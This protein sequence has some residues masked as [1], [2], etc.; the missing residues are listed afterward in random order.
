MGTISDLEKQGFVVP[1]TIGKP[2]EPE[3]DRAPTRDMEEVSSVLKRKADR[4]IRMG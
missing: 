2:D 3:G 1:H 4:E